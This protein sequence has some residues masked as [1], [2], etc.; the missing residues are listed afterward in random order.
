MISLVTGANGFV[1]SAIVRQLLE[2][3]HEVRCLV[4]PGS[5]QRNLQQL[6]VQISTGDLRQPE[7]LKQALKG[8]NNLFHAAADY[9]LWI[10]D[11][12]VMYEVNVRGT[13]N[14]LLAAH[15]EGLDRIIYTSS[16]ATLGLNPD[17]SPADEKTPSALPDMTGHYKRSKFM[18]EQ[19]TMQ[20]TGQLGLPLVTVNPSTPIGPRDIR[21][22]PTGRMVIDTLN[23]DMPAYVNTGLNIVH[24]DDVAKG[25]LLAFN[26]GHVGERYILGGE[27]M[28]LL[29]ILNTID[30][31]SGMPQ[32][33]VRLPHQAVLPVAWIMELVA[34]CTGKEPRATVDSVRM[35][36]K[37]MFFSSGKAVRELG[38]Q[39]RPAR[40]ALEDAVRWF[41]ENDYCRK[42][43][44]VQSR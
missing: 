40:E 36:R 27:N 9:R 3:G 20:L 29:D 12:S 22:T 24:V 6:P 15:A 5:N 18:A 7:S 1:G 16:V 17:H 21:P 39:F 28:T 19:K 38:Y 35:A 13:E 43:P 32:K 14:L 8:C 37:T 34:R 23:G 10:P 11:P 26:S 2:S 25:H 31:I 33:R 4:R 41:V 44:T 42:L 30:E